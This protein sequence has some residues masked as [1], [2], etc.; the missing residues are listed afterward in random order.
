M[1][2]KRRLLVAA[3][4]QDLRTGGRVREGGGEA[5]AKREIIVVDG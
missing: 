5:G 4:G 1:R 3:G 2:G